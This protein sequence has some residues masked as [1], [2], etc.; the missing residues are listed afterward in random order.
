MIGALDGRPQVG[1]QAFG[2]VLLVNNAAA[3]A[4]YDATITDALQSRAVRFLPIRASRAA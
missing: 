3:D 1:D 4:E 2:A